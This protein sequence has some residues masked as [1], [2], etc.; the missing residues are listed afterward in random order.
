MLAFHIMLMVVI[1]LTMTGLGLRLE[2]GPVL[3]AGR[4]W[5]ALLLLVASKFLLV[6][7]LAWLV[8]QA[9]GVEGRHAMAVAVVMLGP[10]GEIAA[11]A[12]FLAHASLPLAVL[13]VVAINVLSPLLS[14]ALIRLVTQASEDEYAVVLPEFIDSVTAIFLVIMLPLAL[15]MALR[16]LTPN[17][18]EGVTRQFRAFIWVMYCLIAVYAILL[19]AF[20]ESDPNMGAMLPSLAGV[21]LAALFAFAVTHGVGRM[22]GLRAEYSITA[23][24]LVGLQSPGV[25]L[26]VLTRQTDQWPEL[27]AMSIG[28]AILLPFIVAIWVVLAGRRMQV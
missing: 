9:T 8:I 23:S 5:G 17:L 15:G 2:L 18:A 3:R 4:Q 27:A 12:V 25:G 26:Y 1:V 20:L 7:L 13:G 6:P 21:L 14:P 16:H 28:Y 22:C 11:A 24:F 19:Q 10:G